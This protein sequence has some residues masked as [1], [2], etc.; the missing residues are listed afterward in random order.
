MSYYLYAVV[1]SENDSILDSLQDIL[2][3]YV[4]DCIGGCFTTH[5]SEPQNH[6]WQE[7]LMFKIMMYCKYVYLI[8]GGLKDHLGVPREFVWAVSLCL[9]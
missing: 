7:D 9:T 2:S 5:S 6:L 1:L 3:V 4:R 8:I